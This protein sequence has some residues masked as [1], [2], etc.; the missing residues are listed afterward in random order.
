MH[1]L[2]KHVQM[3]QSGKKSKTTHGRKACPQHQALY[4]ASIHLHPSPR[5][6]LDTCCFCICH[7]WLASS[8]S[9][10]RGH[11]PALNT[12]LADDCG[13]QV[14]TVSPW[15]AYFLLAERSMTARTIA[16]P[17]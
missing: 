4:I 5:V 17:A 6:Q 16:S 10:A 15:L 13:Q 1:G 8:V 2:T 12:C 11:M 9:C 7:S 14:I 3:P